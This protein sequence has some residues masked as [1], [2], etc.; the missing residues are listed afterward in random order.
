MN[1]DVELHRRHIDVIIA[2][3]FQFEAMILTQVLL[4]NPRRHR[5]VMQPPC[6]FSG[7]S[8]CLPF[9]ITS[10][11]FSIAFRPSFLRPP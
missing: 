9:E 5:G 4:I 8:F 11:H 7:I 6:G 10:H 1:I 2:R 3:V